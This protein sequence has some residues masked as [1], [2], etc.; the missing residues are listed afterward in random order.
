MWKFKAWPVDRSRKTE[1]VRNRS[2]SKSCKISVNPY[3]RAWRNWEFSVSGTLSE[4][5]KKGIKWPKLLPKRAEPYIIRTN[6][7]IWKRKQ[8][9]WDTKQILYWTIRQTKR[10]NISKPNTDVQNKGIGIL[11]L[12][13]N[14]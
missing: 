8:T 2:S 4:R 6:R 5:W 13:V 12:Q 9:L 10:S 11:Q 3:Q 7:A 1:E 14:E